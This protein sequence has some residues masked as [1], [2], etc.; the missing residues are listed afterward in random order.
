M[1]GEQKESIYFTHDNGGRPF[2]VVVEDKSVKVF[3]LVRDSG[4]LY[5]TEPVFANEDCKSVWVGKSPLMEMTKFS[6][7]H[8]EEFDGN[9][10]LVETGNNRYTHIGTKILPFSTLAPV[11]EFVSPVGNN[12]VPYPHA[13]DEKG[14]YY[15]LIENVVLKARDGLKKDIEDDVYAYF[16]AKSKITEEN[17]GISGFRIGESK[18]NLTYTSTPGAHFDSWNRNMSIRRTDSEEFESLSRDEYISLHNDF[19]LKMGFTPL[20]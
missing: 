6:G 20:V 15:L 3:S 19:G 17:F 8:G 5:S 4:G 12:D 16:Y 13:V 11:Q 7:G 10:I 2:K 18:Y 14:N 9:S 1:A